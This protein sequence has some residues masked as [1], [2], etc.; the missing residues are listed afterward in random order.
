MGCVDEADGGSRIVVVADSDHGYDLG[1]PSQAHGGS[2]V[3]AVIGLEQT[4]RLSQAGGA[5]ACLV[6]VDGSVPDCVSAAESEAPGQSAL[7]LPLW[8]ARRCGYLAAV[9]VTISPRM[10]VPRFYAAALGLA[11]N[12][13]RRAHHLSSSCQN[14]GIC[15]AGDASF[16]LGSALLASDSCP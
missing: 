9:S 3:T 8:T 11:A 5:D 16:Q 10:L 15:Q 7:R 13:A 12:G 14:S 6:T 1:C 4:R 2:P